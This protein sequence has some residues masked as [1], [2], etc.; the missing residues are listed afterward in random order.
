MEAVLFL[1]LL[2][3]A[4]TYFDAK[5]TEF[6]GTEKRLLLQAENARLRLALDAAHADVAEPGERSERINA[7]LSKRE[8]WEPGWEGGDP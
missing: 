6:D 5:A 1:F 7:K 4:A 2:W 8:P 3:V